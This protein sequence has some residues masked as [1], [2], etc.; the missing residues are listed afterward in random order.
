M[1]VFLRIPGL[2]GVEECRAIRAEIDVRLKD[3]DEADE[4]NGDGRYARTRVND[5]VLAG[6]LQERLKARGGGSI[7]P[8]YDEWRMH[9][10]VF[11]T[12]YGGPMWSHLV[13]KRRSFRDEEK[14]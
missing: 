5:P 13:S 9:H 8:G 1:S 7:V 3:Y 2:L 10:L 14:K 12:R 4:D 11:F 6:K